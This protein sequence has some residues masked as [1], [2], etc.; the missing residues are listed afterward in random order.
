M[1][2][3]AWTSKTLDPPFE[4]ADGD[5]RPGETRGWTRKR[6][7]DAGRGSW[8]EENLLKLFRVAVRIGVA[9]GDHFHRRSVDR[10]LA[11]AKQCGL[12]KGWFFGAN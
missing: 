12:C 6:G 9:R 5:C 7:L 4:S 11:V 1:V 10:V 2:R 3:D 8:G